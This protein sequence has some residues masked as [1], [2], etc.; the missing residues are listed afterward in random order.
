M[1][2]LMNT[3]AAACTVALAATLTACGTPVAAPREPVAQTES[4]TPPAAPKKA[5]DRGDGYNLTQ[6]ERNDILLEV[7]RDEIPSM[8][9]VPD[10]LILDM[11]D[12]TC[13]VLDEGYSFDDL[14]GAGLDSGDFFTPRQLGFLAGAAVS[15]MCP[16]HEGRLR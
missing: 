5:T 2:I 8:A 9:G 14:I 1:N 6:S 12:S 4:Q 3:A 15:A 7:V 11:A 10:Y 13:L 16:E